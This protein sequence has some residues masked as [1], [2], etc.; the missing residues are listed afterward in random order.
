MRKTLEELLSEMRQEIAQLKR[1][2]SRKPAR[3]ATPI[4]PRRGWWLGVTHTSLSPG[5]TCTVAIWHWSIEDTKWIPALDTD[6]EPLTVTAQDWFLN[7]TD[8][9]I[10]VG[11]KVRVDR[12]DNV[13]YVAAAYCDV[14]DNEDVVA[15]LPE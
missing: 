15:S 2:I 12:Y 8:D 3:D 14:S 7:S 10:A 11:T 13:W 6:D 9:A 1:E 5:S 4:A